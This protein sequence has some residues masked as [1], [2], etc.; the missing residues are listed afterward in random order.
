MADDLPIGARSGPSGNP[1]PFLD[2]V[3][4]SS[5]LSAL[6]AAVKANARQAGLPERRAE[7]V[8]LSV[9]ELATNAIRHGGGAGRLRMWRLG[10][11]LRCQVADS[12]RPAPQNKASQGADHDTVAGILRAVPVTSLRSGPGHG[13]WLVRKVADR[14]RIWSDARGVRVIVTFN[15]RAQHGDMPA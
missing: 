12:E 10:G 2:L 6:R 11:A 15:I 9:H 1:V 5:T 3:F 8:V 4:E 7:D 13:L 14:V